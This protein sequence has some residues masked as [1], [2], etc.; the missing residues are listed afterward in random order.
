M[1]GFSSRGHAARRA[2]RK[3]VVGGCQNDWAGG[4]ARA[5]TPCRACLAR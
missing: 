1:K 2:G 3:L 4:V 5:R